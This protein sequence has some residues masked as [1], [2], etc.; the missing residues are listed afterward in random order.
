[1]L[2]LTDEQLQ[3]IEKYY[4]ENMKKGLLEK[5]NETIR[6]RYAAYLE[7]V[8]GMLGVTVDSLDNVLDSHHLGKHSLHHQLRFNDEK[9]SFNLANENL[10]DM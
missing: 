10:K 3:T 6:D 8:A 4:W 9:D 5:S 1:M 7:G 2:T